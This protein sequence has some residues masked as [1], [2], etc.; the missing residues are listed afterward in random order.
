MAEADEIVEIVDEIADDKPEYYLN[1]ESGR[2][3]KIGSP[4]YKKLMNKMKSVK[5]P[6]KQEVEPTH[7]IKMESIETNTALRN[8]LMEQ[9]TNMV[10]ENINKIGNV[11]KLTDRQ[12]DKQLRTMLISKLGLSKKSKKRKKKKS[13]FKIVAPPVSSSSESS[14][15]ESSD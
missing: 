3:L 11:D 6:V 13:K 15:S 10:R 7:N 5:Q 12:L 4:T 8:R 14:E 9:S 1:P 2:Y